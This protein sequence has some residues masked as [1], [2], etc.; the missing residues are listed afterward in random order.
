VPD[1]ARPE[2]AHVHIRDSRGVL[3]GSGAV[4]VNLFMDAP[5]P[6]VARS[7][8]LEQVRRIAPPDPPG[9]EDRDAEMAE[10]ARFCIAPDGPSYA[11]W[12]AGPWAGKS[13]LLSTFVLCPP[14]EVAERATI[15]SFF[16]TSR[17][18]AQDSREAFTQVMLEQLAA[19]LGQPLP[20]VLPE[21]TREAY[22]LDLMTQA[23]KHCQRADGLLLL[24]VDGLDED[25]GV[26]TGPDAH[27]IAGLLPASPPAGMRVLVAGRPH[28]PVPDDVPDWH[29]LRDPAIIR[30]LSASPHA[31]DVR[32]LGRQELQ[33][34]LRGSTAEQDLLGLLA[35]ARGGLTARDLADLAGVPLWEVENVLHTA[36]GRTLQGRPSLIAA[37]RRPDVYLLG[38]EELQAAATDY[39]AGRL[40]GYRQRLHDWADGWSATRWPPETPEYL[41]IGYFRLVDDL[42]DLPRMT[43]YAL[44]TAR[45][46]RML[47]LTGGD[48]AALVETRIVL[49]RI[50]SQGEPDL[51]AA[52]SLACHRDYLRR[53]SA[54]IPPRLPA[55]W[56]T[57][58]QVSR[59]QALALAIT[60]SHLRAEA[61]AEVA[62]ALARAG[63]HERAEAVA[64]AVADPGLQARAL[65]DVAGA[66][67]RAGQ[68]ERAEN[69]ARS[70]TEPGSPAYALA[71]V[72]AAQAEA[73]HHYRAQETA[74]S[75]TDPAQRAGALAEVA[76]ALARTGKDALARAAGVR[77]EAAVRAIT[78]WHCPPE[79]IVSQV[80]AALAQSGQHERALAIARLF[81]EADFDQER[82]LTEVARALARAGKRERA[83][84]IARSI[85]DRNPRARA[86]AAVAEALAQAG[87]HEEAEAVA[88]SVADPR[89]QA[90]ALA[91]IAG[92]LTK[93]GRHEQARVLAARAEEVAQP[94]TDTFGQPGDGLAEVAETLARAGHYEQAEAIA[95]SLPRPILQASALA[96]VAVAL[97][98]AKRHHQAA[99][100]A[101][102]SEDITRSAAN[103][104]SRADDL[105][106]IAGALAWAGQHQQ[107]E[108]I[109]RSLPDWDSQARALSEV[110]AAL[111]QAG[112]H[113]QAEDIVRSV[114]QPPPAP[115]ASTAIPAPFHHIMEIGASHAL[116]SAAADVVGALAR[117]GDYERAEAITESL[118][119]SARARALSQVAGALARA[120]Q[121]QRAG[122]LAM[123][124]RDIAGSL[125]GR[126]ATIEL[127]GV[128]AR[129]GQH[130]VAAD[131]ARA[132]TDP[133]EQARALTEV[134]LAM[135][136]TGQ[137]EQA[138][139]LALEAADVAR[140]ITEPHE[141]GNAMARVAWALAK[142]GK[143]GPASRMAAAACATTDWTTAAR[144]VL[145][146]SPAA[147][148]TIA[149]AMHGQ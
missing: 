116:Q 36:A 73:G 31:R 120:G 107:A 39:L 102:R 104:D 3:V 118:S 115:Y 126:G 15:V 70:V 113:Q 54:R 114:S 136:L 32:R 60:H 110:A 26:T 99:T 138:G 85:P 44:D 90:C 67:A 94:V 109:A 71:Q 149:T 133:G 61:L 8:Y 24:V 17:L 117:Q 131:V 42:A 25:R 87:Q 93:A 111:A 144:P 52:L 50:A 135:T 86:L 21:A 18:A 82:P 105:R 81:P 23:A 58:G 12:Q 78:V 80:A 69:I 141:H 65:G 88:E 108:A 130:K 34:L 14:R 128:L 62:A 28:P 143:T 96:E 35:A 79:Y 121:H 55:V 22:L 6:P 40:A 137:H 30:P 53:R 91:A 129:A 103:H 2:S 47:D 89:A 142:A 48:A 5:P 4:Q 46:D 38:H 13:A 146:I 101:Q 76:M 37:A 29:P 119:G 132:S 74:G 1:E 100:L 66:L 9:L 45:H 57:V 97:A 49:D 27:S 134:V 140:S 145:L 72:A 51:V 98:Q 148:T 16:I 64:R 147:F 127:A 112:Q 139:T 63:Q 33:R 56:A 123:Q 43:R 41:L 77:A 106:E 125:I 83:E 84:A 20:A 7:A 10:L 92:A 75:V 19:L 124:A 68:Y 95:R 59:A 11:W 122:T